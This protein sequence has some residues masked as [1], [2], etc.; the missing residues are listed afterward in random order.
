MGTIQ[1]HRVISSQYDTSQG[2]CS[3]QCEVLVS[4]KETI[5]VNSKGTIIR[6]HESLEHR[7]SRLPMRW[8]SLHTTPHGGVLTP[9]SSGGGRSL[10]L[11]VLPHP[12]AAAL[13]VHDT[14]APLAGA[15]PDPSGQRPWQASAA[16]M[17]RMS[18]ATGSSATHTHCGERDRRVR[19]YASVLSLSFTALSSAKSSSICTCS[20]STSCKP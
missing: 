9:F 14:G 12:G 7:F 17:A 13:G 16:A 4:R 8:A 18:L 6:A 15:L 20:T 19:A 1:F 3:T 11:S 10:A 2:K 5:M